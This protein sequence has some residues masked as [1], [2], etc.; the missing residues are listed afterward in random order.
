[1]RHKKA[2]RQDI[3]IEKGNLIRFKNNTKDLQ[4]RLYQT[5][6]KI[7]PKSNRN[8]QKSVDSQWD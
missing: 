8:L 6:L 4:F 1:M 3:I 2:L 7:P 5:H